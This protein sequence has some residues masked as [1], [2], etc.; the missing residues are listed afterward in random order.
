M[1]IAGFDPLAASR[2][3]MNADTRRLARAANREVPDRDRG[4]REFA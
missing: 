3:A 4:Q 2:E 1:T